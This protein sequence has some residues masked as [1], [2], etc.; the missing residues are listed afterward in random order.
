MGPNSGERMSSRE[1]LGHVTLTSNTNISLLKKELA[2]YTRV[3][4]VKHTFND[5]KLYL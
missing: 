2:I 4:M 5:K 3:Y 1:I